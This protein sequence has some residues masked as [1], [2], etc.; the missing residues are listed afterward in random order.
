MVPKR[1]AIKKVID[2]VFSSPGAPTTPV[3]VG[4]APT[5]TPTVNAAARSQ[6]QGEGARIEV[7][8]GTNTKGLAT[9]AATNLGGQGLNV[10]K[11]GDA[12]RYDYV[13]SV[14]VYYANKPLTQSYLAQL[15]KVAPENIRPS[16]TT[17]KDAD[18]R[19]ILGSSAPVP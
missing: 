7:L 1:D 4:Q 15:F 2:E 3:T 14:I 16:P 12:G 19:I 11:I 18:I 17:N 6:M 13:D 9:R 10:V 5:P 8:N